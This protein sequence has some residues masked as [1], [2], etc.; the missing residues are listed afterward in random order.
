MVERY[1]ENGNLTDPAHRSDHAFLKEIKDK[2]KARKEM[3]DKIKASLITA[4]IW[5]IMGGIG[6]IIWYAFNEKI[7]K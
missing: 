2:S 7:S 3:H 1:D 5:S 6:S 4:F